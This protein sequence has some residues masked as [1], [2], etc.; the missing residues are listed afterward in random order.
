[1][2]TGYLDN[3]I[4]PS[5]VVR[6]QLPPQEA[7]ALRELER[8]RTAGEIAL[9]TSHVTK[10]EITK[11]PAEHRQPLD[12]LYDMYENVPAM[13]EGFRMPRG[14][15]SLRSG[16]TSGPIVQ[17]EALGRLLSL[18][19]DEMDARHIFQAAKNGL[20]YF[21]TRDEETI[22]KYEAEIRSAVGIQALL[23]TELLRRLA[24]PSRTG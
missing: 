8:R 24:S 17:D 13:E 11:T 20:D 3:C 2:E 12:D 18:L 1:V 22:L 9:Y 10:E 7:A 21:I 4:V 14:L 19:P 6:K 23:P 5:G 15:G 16:F